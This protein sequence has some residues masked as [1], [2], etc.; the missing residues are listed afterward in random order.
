MKLATQLVALVSFLCL[1]ASVVL[2]DLSRRTAVRANVYHMMISNDVM[3]LLI[4][5]SAENRQWQFS[6]SRQG[7]S[8]FPEPQVLATSSSRA[9]A[10][11]R[12]NQGE[13][14]SEGLPEL[15]LWQAR[16]SSFASAFSGW[17]LGIRAGC[18][19]PLWLHWDNAYCCYFQISKLFPTVCS[20]R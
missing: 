14:I 5:T 13:D 4:E 7:R 16:Y 19:C 2:F 8:C 9:S 11:S 18:L 10:A 17:L 1:F 15:N 20:R 12:T 6:E 3:P